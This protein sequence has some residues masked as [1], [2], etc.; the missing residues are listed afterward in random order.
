MRRND[1]DGIAGKRLANA[2]D[3]PDNPVVPGVDRSRMRSMPST[4]ND[5]TSIASSIE[6]ALKNIGV[7]SRHAQSQLKGLAK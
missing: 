4:D 2:E 5:S 7:R 6:V 1:D 3:V